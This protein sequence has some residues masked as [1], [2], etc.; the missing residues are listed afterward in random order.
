MNLRLKQEFWIGKKAEATI[1]WAVP[2]R[3]ERLGADP[4]AGRSRWGGF[5]GRGGAGPMRVRPTSL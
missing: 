3:V 4:A 1:L 2:V 5:G